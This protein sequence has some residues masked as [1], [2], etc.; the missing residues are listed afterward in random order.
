M[1]CN[2][3]ELGYIRPR[4][5]ILESDDILAKDRAFCGRRLSWGSAGARIA[6]GK[7]R[8]SDCDSRVLRSASGLSFIRCSTIAAPA[9]SKLKHAADSWSFATDSARRATAHARAGKAMADCRTSRMNN[10]HQSS[11]G[12]LRLQ[13]DQIVDPYSLTASFNA[14]IRGDSD[15]ARKRPRAQIGAQSQRVILRLISEDQVLQ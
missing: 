6:Y 1:G 4:R 5:D 9:S 7:R 12:L 10:G 2:V 15:Q 11:A 13:F 3:V 14:F 8:H